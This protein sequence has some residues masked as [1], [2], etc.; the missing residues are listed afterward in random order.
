[1]K[2]PLH[3][4]SLFF[5][6]LILDLLGANANFYRSFPVFGSSALLLLLY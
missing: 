5:S 6:M 3:L 4:C 1:M 2:A